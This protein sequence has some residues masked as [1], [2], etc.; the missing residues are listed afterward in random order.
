L[1]IGRRPFDDE[2]TPAYG[3]HEKSYDRSIVAIPSALVAMLSAAPVFNA[4]SSRMR[5]IALVVCGSRLT[6]A[7][8]LGRAQP[9]RRT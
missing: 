5:R 7:F 1:S 3:T 9:G 6:A 2:H 8:R 4:P